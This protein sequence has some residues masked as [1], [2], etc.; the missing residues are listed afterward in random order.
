M[1]KTINRLFIRN[2]MPRLRVLYH[3]PLTRALICLPAD[4]MDFLMRRRDPFVPPRRIA[5]IGPGDYRKNGREFVSYFVQLCDLKPD[6]TVLDP[7]CGPG[8]IAL[9]LTTYL[10]A[11]GRYDGFDVIPKAIDWASTTISPEFS[12]FSFRYVDVYNTVYNPTGR[13]DPADFVFPYENEAFDF[14]FLTSVFTHMLPEDIEHYISEISRVLRPGGRT[15]ISF[16]LL[17]EVSYRKLDEGASAIDFAHDFDK[18]R[19]HNVKTPEI[20]IAYK[21]DYVRELL[22]INGLEIVEPIHYGS[23]SGREEFLSL[24]DIVVAR[25]N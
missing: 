17:N 21:E 15:F 16:F 7:G 4:T 6:E 24:Q 25:K 12:N 22:G 18:Y 5:A 23:W 3:K 9:A 19:L 13:I 8:R 14:V 11:E 1:L 20:D 2:V 10:S